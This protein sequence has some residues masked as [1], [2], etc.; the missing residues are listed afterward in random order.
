M[1]ETIIKNVKNQI[2]EKK[3]HVTKEYLLACIVE[4]LMEIN[5]SLDEI[6]KK[7]K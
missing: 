6:N 3:P 1:S 5:Q 7:L 4:E 2:W